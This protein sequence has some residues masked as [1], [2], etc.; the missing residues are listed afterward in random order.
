MKIRL[1]RALL[2]GSLLAFGLLAAY[3]F[4]KAIDHGSESAYSRDLRRLETAD[5][6][7]NLR[8]LES[9]A[10]LVK[11][12][13][14]LVMGV[15]RLNQL[16]RVLAQ[17]PQFVGAPQVKEI[18][19]AL[20][21]GRE[22]LSAKAEQIEA[23]K[24]HHA[25][26][27][28]SAQF[29]PSVADRVLAAARAESGFGA[30]VGGVLSS[31]MSLGVAPEQ[32]ALD[33]LAQSLDELERARPSDAEWRGGAD[34]DLL[35]SHARLILKSKPVVDASVREALAQPFGPFAAALGE[36]YS[37][38]YRRAL[39]AASARQRLLFAL[40]TLIV[41]LGLSDVIVRLAQSRSALAATGQEL[42]R[43][44]QALEREREKERELG[45]LKSRFVAMTSHEFR[46]PLSA[47]LSSSELLE[48]YGERWDRERRLGHL[49]RIKSCVL[50]M[51]QMLD[52]ILV[53]GRAEAGVLR[54][55]PLE[56]DLDVFCKNLVEAVEA[57]APPGGTDARGRIQYRFNGEPRVSVD[58]LLLRHVL[59]NLLGNAIKYSPNDA[60]VELEVQVDAADCRFVVRDR[61][62]GIPESDVPRIFE[63]FQRG[64]NVGQ[65][66][67]SGL[68]MAVVK[69]AL[70]VQRGSIDVKTAV[71]VG[72]EFRVQI[73]HRAAERASA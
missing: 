36:S 14:A 21:R 39:D 26:L 2:G 12:Y 54:P 27:R 60:A 67:G 1:L 56:L 62:I 3:A 29:L 16:L 37:E 69:R 32:A 5:A 53:I 18:R 47:I 49:G 35:L 7:L 31:F 71:G 41:T 20:E 64:S 45:E 57:S 23:F 22:L 24:T 40:A 25:V 72:S 8:L 38:Q 73:P 34:F 30:R 17:P 9:R 46:T 19:A 52:Q 15:G 33:R 11:H 43:A 63:S 68:G 6:E 58:E 50:S 4:A 70:G 59:S 48:T 44:N 61:G 65:I 55:N 66:G 42:S 13:D 10:G 51:T 28:N